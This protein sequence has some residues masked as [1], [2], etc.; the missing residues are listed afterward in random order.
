MM[1]ISLLQK[2]TLTF[3]RDGGDGYW[4][5]DGQW[6]EAAPITVQA[7]G[8]LQPFR[9]GKEQIILPEG[10][11]SDDAFIFYTK[12]L[13]QTASQFTKELADTTVIDSRDYYV[14][15]AEDWSKQPGLIPIHWKTILM[16][17]DQPTGG[18]I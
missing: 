4:N 13:L 8:N 9:Q 18:S 2:S 17:E 1:A 16:R 15:S 6:V 14:L 7:I 3:T 11:K 12:T 10:K 5:E